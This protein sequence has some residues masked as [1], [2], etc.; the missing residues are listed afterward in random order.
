MNKAADKL[1]FLNDPRISY[2]K[3]SDY[4]DLK[5]FAKGK[6]LTQFQCEELDYK[7]H[8]IVF[9]QRYNNDKIKFHKTYK[10]YLN[11]LNIKLSVEA[12]GLDIEKFWFFILY[13]YDLSEQKTKKIEVR[14]ESARTQYRNFID[15]L[16]SAFELN[17]DNDFVVDRLGRAKQLKDVVIEIKIDG[18]KQKAVI[19]NIYALQ[20]LSHLMDGYIHLLDDND[21]NFDKRSLTNKCISETLGSR[22]Y[23]I[24]TLFKKLFQHLNNDLKK[25]KSNYFNKNQLIAEILYFMNLIKA[26]QNEEIGRAHV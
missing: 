10:D 14:E 4:Y 1:K 13:A 2:L 18:K 7:T 3:S 21:S 25:G 26:K 20:E 17:N 22:N 5:T 19:D 8:G 12:L 16:D 24:I 15:T 23:L 6:K 11:N 9:Y